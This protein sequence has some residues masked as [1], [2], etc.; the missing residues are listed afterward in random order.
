MSKRDAKPPL[1][2]SHSSSLIPRYQ[3]PIAGGLGYL[4]VKLAHAAG[5]PI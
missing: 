3:P 1:L 2:V 5:L 4:L